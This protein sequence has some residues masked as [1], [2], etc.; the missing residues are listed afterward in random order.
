MNLDEIERVL[1]RPL[2]DSAIVRHAFAPYMR[3]YDLII[4][5][6]EHHFLYRFTHCTSATY[7]TRVVDEAWRASWDDVFTDPDGYERAG[8]PPGFFWGTGWAL[9]YPGATLLKDSIQAAQWTGRLGRTMYHVRI[10]T[11]AFN[12]E[13]IFHDLV[14]RELPS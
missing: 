4:V 2:F 8:N 5:I 9:A 7:E 12:L 14:F 6:G 10:E 1:E 3:D 11:N 13:L